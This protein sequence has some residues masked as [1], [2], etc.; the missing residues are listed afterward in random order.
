MAALLALEL[1]RLS[2]QHDSA[3]RALGPL[4]RASSG[5]TAAW[6]PHHGAHRGAQMCQGERE[7]MPRSQPH[8]PYP[9]PAPTHTFAPSPPS[10][11]G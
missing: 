4:A 8:I 3:R 10:Q 1:R 7:P 2:G 11:L 6:P 5:R 9:P